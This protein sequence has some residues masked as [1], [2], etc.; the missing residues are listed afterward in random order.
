MQS[1]PQ[2]TS[3]DPYMYQDTVALGY[4]GE[5]IFSILTKHVEEWYKTRLLPET[6]PIDSVSYEDVPKNVLYGDTLSETQRVLIVK[7]RP[8]KSPLMPG[9]ADVPRSLFDIYQEWPVLDYAP[10]VHFVNGR[11]Q[12]RMHFKRE[13]LPTISP[14]EAYQLY[15]MQIGGPIDTPQK[16]KLFDLFK[17]FESAKV[18][19]MSKLTLEK[20]PLLVYVRYEPSESYHVDARDMSYGEV[21]EKMTETGGYL[22]MDGELSDNIYAMPDSGFV[23]VNACTF[24]CSPNHE[25]M[26]KM[27]STHCINESFEAQVRKGL[28]SI[29][30]NFVCIQ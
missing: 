7:Y 8:L 1:Q 24:G 3:E 9:N 17:Q 22:D 28:S 5:G 13:Y 30:N 10:L 23:K 18:P 26:S 27:Q 14:D 6:L 29:C 15:L 20:I 25:N 4:D 19:N 12:I 2:L 16:I 11:Y 21:I